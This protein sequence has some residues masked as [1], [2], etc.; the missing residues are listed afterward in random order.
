MDKRKY[1]NRLTPERKK[2]SD[3]EFQ[4]TMVGEGQICVLFHN[5]HFYTMMNAFTESL[6]FTPKARQ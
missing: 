3:Q 1:T 2:W 4:V 6:W 5:N